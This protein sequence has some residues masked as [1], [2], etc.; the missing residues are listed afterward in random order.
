MLWIWI[1]IFVL[2]SKVRSILFVCCFVCCLCIFEN[3]VIT[4]VY[5]LYTII[6]LHINSFLCQLLTVLK[7]FIVIAFSFATLFLLLFYTISKK[8]KFNQ[9]LTHTHTYARKVIQLNTE[10]WN[11]NDFLMLLRNDTTTTRYD[12]V[13]LTFIYVF[14]FSCFFVFSVFL[15]CSVLKR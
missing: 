10:K 2:Y 6:T 5:T 8:T 14:F 9:S 7:R 1:V 3:V 12:S 13:H 15:S 4:V 11:Q